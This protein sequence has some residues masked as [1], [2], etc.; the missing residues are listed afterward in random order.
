M[1]KEKKTRGKLKLMEYKIEH[2]RI[3]KKRIKKRLF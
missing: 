1:R 3:K 2:T